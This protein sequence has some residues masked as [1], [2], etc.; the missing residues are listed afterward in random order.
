MAATMAAGR[1]DTE[2][3]FTGI[4]MGDVVAKDNV[5][6]EKISHTTGL[7]GYH[8]GVQSFGF[9]DDGTGFIGK[10][11]TGRIEFNGNS[12]TIQSGN[13]TATEGATGTLIDLDNGSIDMKGIGAV[14]IYNFNTQSYERVNPNT[15]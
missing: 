2:N 12:G 15:E 11:G 10:S 7:Y 4:I 6:Q 14:Y 3:R 1:K 9:L 5:R 8:K 13:Y